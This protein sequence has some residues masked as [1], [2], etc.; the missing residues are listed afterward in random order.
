MTSRR[1]C[2]V[3]TLLAALLLACSSLL[4]GQDR[5]SFARRALE[6]FHEAEV[7]PDKL[8]PVET[9]LRA[10]REGGR[11]EELWIE[12]SNAIDA[13]AQRKSVTSELN[14]KTSP[15]GGATIKCQTI[16]ERSRGET[17]RTLGS[18][19]LTESVGIGDYFIWAERNATPTSS[20][21]NRYLI[22]ARKEHVSISE[23]LREKKSLK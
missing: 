16:G 6:R 8:I 3:A 23:D 14:V 1:F 18:S 21:N 2:I 10:W 4:A 19:E 5:E 7:P 22:V 11:T 13:A 17:P 9:S 15:D 20:K 12:V